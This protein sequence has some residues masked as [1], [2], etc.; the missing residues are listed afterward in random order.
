LALIAQAVF[1]LEGGQS[2]RETD[3]TDATDETTHALATVG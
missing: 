1:L 3:V 2:H